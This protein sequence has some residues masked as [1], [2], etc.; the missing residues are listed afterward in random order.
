MCVCVFVCIYT[1]THTHTHTQSGIC[2]LRG[3]SIGVMVFLLYKMYVLLPYTYPTPKLSPHRR[4]CIS[5]FPP[6]NSHCMIYERFELWGHWKCPHKSTSPCYTCH[7]N[8]IIQMCV[9][10]NHINHIHI[11]LHAHTHARTHAR[12]HLHVFGGF[13]FSNN[14]N[15]VFSR[16]SFYFIFWRNSENSAL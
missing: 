2:G 6:K 7:T 9:L 5:I 15:R 16:V 4:R 14:P 12:T 10:I 1:H 13:S 8:A 3:L 11:H